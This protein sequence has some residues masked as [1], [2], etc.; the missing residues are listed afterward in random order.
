MLIYIFHQKKKQKLKRF[1]PRKPF[2]ST[3]IKKKKGHINVTVRFLEGEGSWVA[4]GPSAPE[5][6]IS[7]SY[8]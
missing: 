8:L 3:I 6:P 7:D 5:F 4:Q 1:L 2:I